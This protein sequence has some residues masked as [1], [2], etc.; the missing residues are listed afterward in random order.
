MTEVIEVAAGTELQRL[1]QGPGLLFKGLDWA[2]DDTLLIHN[3]FTVLEPGATLTF[4]NEWYRIAALN[5][6]SG[7]SKA[8]LKWS[9][10]AGAHLI[11]ARAKA[12]HGHH[13]Q[14]RHLCRRLAPIQLV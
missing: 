9:G 14:L 2:D 7:A 11:S 1:H 3:T 4:Q 5:I 13:G 12:R 8:L 10:L 6:R